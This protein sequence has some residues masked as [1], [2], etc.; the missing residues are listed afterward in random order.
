MR[1]HHVKRVINARRKKATTVQ[2]ATSLGP[3]GRE[4]NARLIQVAPS[5]DEPVNE[6]EHPECATKDVSS[7]NRDSN[8]SVFY[9]LRCTTDTT[10][11]HCVHT[12]HTYRQVSRHTNVI[13]RC[14]SRH[15]NVGGSWQASLVQRGFHVAP[16]LRGCRCN[17]H[18]KT[19]E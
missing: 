1:S 8:V 13:H 16:K 4:R 17:R 10:H 12:S 19:R 2:D 9:A 3:M 14:V 7:S 15:T 11:T 6:P 5:S 18:C